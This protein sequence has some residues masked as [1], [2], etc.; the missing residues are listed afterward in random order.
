MPLIP[1]TRQTLLVRLRDH[2][3]HSAWS[4]FVRLYEP[5]VYRLGRYFGLQDADAQDLV[6]DVLAAVARSVDD[7][8]P[9]RQQGRFRNWLFCVAKN[10]ACNQVRRRRDKLRGLGGT[11]FIA[12]LE[13][14]S[15]DDPAATQF[16]LEYRREVFRHAAEIVERD[17]DAKTWR[18]FQRTVIEQEPIASAAGALGLSMGAAYTARNRVLSRLKR[19]VERMSDQ[20]RCDE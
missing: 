12:R 13:A 14:V 11:S 4:E 9:D 8:D 3:D 10:A 1:D 2:G 20:E 7:W 17:V 15:V 6:Q 19:E 5:A 18:L 16:E